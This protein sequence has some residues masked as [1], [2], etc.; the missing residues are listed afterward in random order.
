MKLAIYFQ[1]SEAEMWIYVRRI[2]VRI[3]VDGDT[4]R[5][6]APLVVLVQRTAEQKKLYMP[7]VFVV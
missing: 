5:S 6:S 7:A 4:A 1:N 2:D 3:S